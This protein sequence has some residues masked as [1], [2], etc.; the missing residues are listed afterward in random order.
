M[1]KPTEAALAVEK[2]FYLY[3]DLIKNRDNGYK[4]I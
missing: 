4:T 2:C 1:I 3:Q